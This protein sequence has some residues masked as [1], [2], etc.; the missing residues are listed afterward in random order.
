M[1]AAPLSRRRA[2]ATPELTQEDLQT[3]CK[4]LGE[5]IETLQRW[6]AQ[7]QVEA[8]PCPGGCLLLWRNAA[9]YTL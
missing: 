7:T 3:F 2:M 8:E 5:N 4:D 9:C 1:Y 6:L